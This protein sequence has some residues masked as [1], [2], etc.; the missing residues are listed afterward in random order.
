MAKNG[1]V[2]QSLKPAQDKRW[3]PQRRERY[4]LILGDGDIKRFFWDN[5]FFDKKAWR[6]GNCFRLRKDAEQ[7]RVLFRYILNHYHKEY[8]QT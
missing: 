8:A 6:L 5:T 7:A 3:K 2:L 4:Y 1:E